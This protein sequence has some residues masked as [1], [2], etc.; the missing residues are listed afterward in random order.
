MWRWYLPDLK[1]K[2]KPSRW[3]MSEANAQAWYPGCTRV[4]GSLEVRVVGDYKGHSMPS[5]LV[6]RE[7]G[8]MMPPSQLRPPVLDR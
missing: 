4:E 5:G 7:D 3:R 2:L 8:A 1:G 6:Q